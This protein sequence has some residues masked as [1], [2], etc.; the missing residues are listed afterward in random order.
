MRKIQL[1]IITAA[2]ATAMS[3]SA[4]LYN[5]AYTE[6]P[7]SGGTVT[8]SGWLDVNNGGVAQSGSLTVAGSAGNLYDG[9]Y[10]LRT[11]PPPPS[12]ANGFDYDNLVPIAPGN[13]GISWTLNAYDVNMWNNGTGTAWGPAGTFSLW[14][15]NGS[16]QMQTYGATTLTPVPEPTTMIAGALLLLPF[17]ASTLRMLRKTRT[18]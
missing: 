6:A 8:A 10:S 18:A 13:L 15:V 9:V 4:T 14:G 11:V 3:A 2:L 7:N 17:G 12:S 16:F 5:I 1:A